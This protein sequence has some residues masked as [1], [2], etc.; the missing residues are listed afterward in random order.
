MPNG[1]GSGFLQKQEDVLAVNRVVTRLGQRGA[2]LLGDVWQTEPQ[3]N[4]PPAVLRGGVIKVVGSTGWASLRDSS[5]A[6]SRE[7]SPLILAG[8]RRCLET[9]CDLLLHHPT[10]IGR[11]ECL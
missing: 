11:C 1:Q 3:Q 4:A 10:A 6:G 9:L 7:W 2:F 8:L 5:F